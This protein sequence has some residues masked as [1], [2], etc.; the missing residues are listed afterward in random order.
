MPGSTRE[1]AAAEARARASTNV[2]ARGVV[3]VRS[4]G[5]ELVIPRSLGVVATRVEHFVT[6]IA[7]PARGGT[8][9]LRLRRDAPAEVVRYRFGV[10]SGG[11]LVIGQ[12]VDRLDLAS[13]GYV[14]DRGEMLRAYPPIAGSEPWTWLV[15]IPVSRETQV[16]LELRAP[17]AGWPFEALSVTPVR[18]P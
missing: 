14:F 17:D 5:N 18:L 7:Q 1:G 8:G 2:D 13:G 15:E 11:V 4:E 6:D 10:T 12:Q 3:T 9:E 16:S